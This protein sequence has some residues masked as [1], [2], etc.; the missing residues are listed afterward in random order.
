[1][2]VS[3]A[4]CLAS[5]P[6]A[7]KAAVHVSLAT[8][9]ASVL[10]AHKAAVH[11]SLATCLVSVLVAHKAAVHVSLATCLASVLVAHKA[12]VH[13]SLATCL[14]SVLVAH[15]AAVHVSLATS[16]VPVRVFHL[17][18][19]FFFYS[20][21]PGCFWATH[22][23]LVQVRTVSQGSFLTTCPIQFYL[24]NLTSAYVGFIY[25]V[26]AF[27]ISVTKYI[28]TYGDFYISNQIWPK[29]EFPI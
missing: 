11:V 26:V 19:F 14:A 15:K 9:L 23:P 21:S 4:T 25:C 28:V 27:S 10:V 16:L 29:Q 1:M 13:V 2:H 5:V 18:L 12:A 22:F 7:H 6:V 8:S 24:H 17:F 3:L 20:C